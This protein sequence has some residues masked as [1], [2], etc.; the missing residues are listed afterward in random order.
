MKEINKNVYRLC[1]FIG[2]SSQAGLAV[3][4]RQQAGFERRQV[5]ENVSRVAQFL[6]EVLG[7]NVTTGRG[8]TGRRPRGRG[9][10]ENNNGF[11]YFQEGRYN[12]KKLL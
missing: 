10:N 1:I 4:R 8:R 12:L 6:R 9:G 11:H 2:H 5:R 7:N 3:R